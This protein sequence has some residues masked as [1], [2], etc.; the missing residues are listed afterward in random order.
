VPLYLALADCLVSPRHSTDNVPLKV[1]DYM[2]SGKPIIATKGR[3]HEPLLTAERALLCDGNP[4]ALRAAILYAAANPSGMAGLAQVAGDYARRH[5]GWH[6][7]VEF[8]RTT[9]AAVIDRV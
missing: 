2:G 7:F 1:F 6:P 4:D 9:Y 5:F 3:A 8:V